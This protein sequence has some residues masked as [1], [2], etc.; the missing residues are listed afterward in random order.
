MGAGYAVLMGLQIANIA[1]YTK[2]SL[3]SSGLYIGYCLGNFVGPLCFR[4]QDTREFWSSSI[5]WC[6]YGIIGAGTSRGCW[7]V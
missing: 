3:S 7:R 4:E 1:G 6:V 2:R 5:E